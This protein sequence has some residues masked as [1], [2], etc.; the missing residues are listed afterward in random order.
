MMM[1]ES[2]KTALKLANFSQQGFAEVR[3]HA[4]HKMQLKTQ[5]RFP[6]LRANS[7]EKGLV[8]PRFKNAHTQEQG[9]TLRRLGRRGDDSG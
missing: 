2:G 9:K 8:L 1:K 6:E 5:A 4:S 3:I 7:E